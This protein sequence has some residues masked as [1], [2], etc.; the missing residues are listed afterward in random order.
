MLA[1]LPEVEQ[2][3]L[4]NSWN[5]KLPSFDSANETTVSTSVE[6]YLCPSHTPTEKLYRTTFMGQSTSWA[7]ASYVGNLGSNFIVDYQDWGPSLQPDGVLYRQSSVRPADISD[8][9]SLTLMAGERV[10]PDM[11]LHPL[12]GFGYTGRV[13]GDSSTEI[14]LPDDWKVHWGFSSFHPGGA[15]FLMSDGSVGMLSRFTD[16]TIFRGLSTRA[17][18][19]AEIERPF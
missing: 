15:H 18:A 17:G 5:T 13:V 14:Q 9:T 8:G 11:L 1:I 2:G 19:E 12:W 10:H 6:V 4:Y 16:M 7:Y 3:Q